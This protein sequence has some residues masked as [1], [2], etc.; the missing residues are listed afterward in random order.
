M[1]LL[2]GEHRPETCASIGLDCRTC[3]QRAADSVARI[4][5]GLS[6]SGAKDVFFQLYPSPG[7]AAMAPAFEA[8]YLEMVKIPA[9]ERRAIAAAA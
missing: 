5:S 8:V 7:C 6:R 3:I 9:G 2:A 4:C 1:D